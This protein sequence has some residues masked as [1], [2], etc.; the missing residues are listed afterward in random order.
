MKK[1]MILVMVCCA[2]GLAG[3]GYP[4]QVLFS[5][6]YNRANSTD[7]DSSSVGMAGVL[8][9]LVYVEAF[10]GSGAATSIQT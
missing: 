6:N 3:A 10:E 9:P 2:P 8:A 4:G 1:L 7:I 5:D